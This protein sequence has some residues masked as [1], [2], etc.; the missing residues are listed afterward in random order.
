FVP[1]QFDLHRTNDD[2]TTAVAADA[3]RLLAR[4]GALGGGGDDHTIS[5]TP[6]SHGADSF[7][8]HAGEHSAIRPQLFRK[9]D[10]L[11]LQ[12]N[13][14]DHAT[15]QPHQLRDQL[16]DQ[17]YA[18]DGDDIPDANLRHAHRIQCNAA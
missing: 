4:G 5:A 10:A 15:W 16:P 9:F 3:Q 18:D 7:C 8:H 13:G 2:H 17:A 6:I 1:G 12:V 11:L 14:D